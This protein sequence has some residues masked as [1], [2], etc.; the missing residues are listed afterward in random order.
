VCSPQIPPIFSHREKMGERTRHRVLFPAPSPE[1]RL[2]IV[3]TLIRLSDAQDLS[4]QQTAGARVLPAVRALIRLSDAQDL[5]SQQTARAR[6]ATREGACAPRRF[7]P[8]LT[9]L[10]RISNAP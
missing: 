2:A 3:R 8:F 1:T 7:L 4:S 10:S 9:T 5:S 6:S